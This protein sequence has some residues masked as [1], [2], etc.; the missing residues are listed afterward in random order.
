MNAPLPPQAEAPQTP[1]VPIKPLFRVLILGAFVVYLFVVALLAFF[2]Q[3]GVTAGVVIALAVL[4]V[5]RALPVALDR[6]EYGWFHPLVFGA[7]LTLLSFLRRI[8]GYAYGIDFHVAL[9]N[10]SRDQL[11]DLMSYELVLS[12]IGMVA[13]Y[14]GFFFLPAPSPPR[15]RFARPRNLSMKVALAVAFA[16]AVFLFYMSTQGGILAHILSWGGSRRVAL[17][18]EYY[19]VPLINMGTVACLIWVAYEPRVVWNP[20]FWGMAGLSALILL[21]SGGSRSGLIYFGIVGMIVWMIRVRKVAVA[22]VALLA[23]LAI[24]VLV[25]LGRLRQS[26]W[27]GRID[28]SVL[29]SLNAVEA[30]QAGVGGEVSE[31][32]TS[33]SATLAILGRVPEQVDLLYGSSYLAAASIPIPRKLWEGKPVLADARAGNVFFGFNAGVVTG[34]IGEAYWNLHIPGVVI[35]FLL[36]GVFHRWLATFL[37]RYP[38]EPAAILFYAVTL[39]HFSSPSSLALVTWMMNLVPLAVLL[40]LF[41]LVG[42]PVRARAASW[43]G[44]APG[45]ASARPAGWR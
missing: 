12:S 3:R 33:E 11:L 26:T 6:G 10:W 5:L 13:Y 14:C 24:A 29:T 1:F 23:V 20:V 28:W 4:V 16:T 32:A 45:L 34:A 17:A 7:L 18:G 41:G 30:F 37:R 42:A 38:R 25:P 43:R 31:R 15:A 22:R 9:P 21:I 39:W 40:L 36:Y 27:S 35:I 44:R 8:G 2:S 19:W